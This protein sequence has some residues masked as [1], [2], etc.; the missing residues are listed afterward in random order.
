MNLA[1]VMAELATRLQ[2]ISGLR[3][4]A[5][6]PDSIS[7][8]AAIVSYPDNI[9]FDE[10]YGRGMDRM[11]LPVV[12]VVGKVSDRATAPALAAYCDGSGVKSLKSVL[13]S[14]TYSAF[15][16]LRVESIDF[17]VVSIAATDYM[18]ALFTIDIAGQGS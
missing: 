13:E 1:N 3:V 9:T 10:T 7:P 12:A 4:F 11:K 5:F 2:T 18:A 16:T 15:H 8:P 14:G 17:D 6:P